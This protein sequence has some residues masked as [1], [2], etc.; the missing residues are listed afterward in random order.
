MKEE[1]IFKSYNQ[2]NYSKKAIKVNYA[3]KK[4]IVYYGGQCP[5]SYDK[6]TTTK[7]INDKIEEYKQ[8]G[9]TVEDYKPSYER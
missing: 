8:L 1:I 2:Y 7:Y 9:F 3:T 6:K 4:I 5:I